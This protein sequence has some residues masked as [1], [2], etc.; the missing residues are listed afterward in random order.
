MAAKKGHKK[1]GGR[2]KGTPNQFTKTVKEVF[3]TVFNELQ[4]NKT[5]NLKEW[6][7]KNTTDF[8]KLSAK[9]IPTDLTADLHLQEKKF[10][11]WLTREIGGN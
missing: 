10:P 7:K 9:L 3:T 5:A 8:Y 11:E 2:V 6:A 1:T 4:V